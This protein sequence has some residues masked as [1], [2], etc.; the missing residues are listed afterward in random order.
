MTGH[1]DFSGK[2]HISTFNAIYVPVVDEGEL[3]PHT[4]TT[5]RKR[6]TQYAVGLSVTMLVVMAIYRVNH[7][8]V[9]THKTIEE[10]IKQKAIHFTDGSYDGKKF[11]YTQEEWHM[12]E[13]EFKF[14]K[15]K[16]NKAYSDVTTNDL[17]FHNFV[18]NYENMLFA[19]SFK[20]LYKAFIN[21]NILIAEIK[22]DN[23][24]VDF[25]PNEW[26]DW[27]DEELKTKIM[28]KNEELEFKEE[29]ASMRKET[30]ESHS[31]E[32]SD[33]VVETAP[34]PEMDWRK[35]NVV[36]VV[37]D[38]G[39]CGSC[40]Y[41]AAVAVVESMNAIAG[42]M[43]ARLSEQELIDCD[44]TNNGCGGSSRPSLFT[45]MK[46][47]GVVYENSYKYKARR[48][49]CRK[50]NGTRVYVDQK[51][52]IGINENQMKRYLA[53][54]GPF[55]IGVS[56]IRELYSYR[57]G[58]FD[59]QFNDCEEKS[60]GMHAMMVVGYGVDNGEDYWLLKNS[61][62]SFGIDNGYVKWKRGVNACGIAKQAWGV[63]VKK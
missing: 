55:S 2:D 25:E 54:T 48:D 30:E 37:K 32:S 40:G 20:V 61:W 59:P 41:F 50:V 12:L 28:S 26:S 35:K 19:E 45:Y 4:K 51:T 60:L 6:L 62:G 13:D 56:V 38:Q 8:K 9:W 39:N 46:D 43:L 17:R 42:N 21:I 1:T 27:T 5:F 44:T 34:L 36:G 33:E 7:M 31:Y 11:Y 63:T 24:N 18:R 10:V 22:D 57:S 49:Q 15:L 52:Y 58:V 53:E 16:F 29:M 3:L 14:Y 23:H 47:H